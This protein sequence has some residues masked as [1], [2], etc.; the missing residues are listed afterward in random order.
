[1]VV[2]YVKPLK[3]VKLAFHALIVIKTFNNLLRN[4]LDYYK[5]SHRLWDSKLYSSATEAAHLEARKI[6]GMESGSADR[7][8][9]SRL[10]AEMDSIGF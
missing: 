7:L 8:F 2:L 3:M 1:M 10:I 9:Y 6:F 5:A 4:L